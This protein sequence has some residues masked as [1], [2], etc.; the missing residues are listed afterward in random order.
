MRSFV[1][2]QIALLIFGVALV[3]SVLTV[4]TVHAGSGGPH[5]HRFSPSGTPCT[6]FTDAGDLECDSNAGWCIDAQPGDLCSQRCTQH[7]T[8]GGALYF[9]FSCSDNQPGC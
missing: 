1:K 8:P 4:A 2:L 6:D 5:T 3:F 9:T 7:T